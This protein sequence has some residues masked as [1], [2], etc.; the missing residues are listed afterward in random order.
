MKRIILLPKKLVSLCLRLTFHHLKNER[1]SEREREES[2]RE[3]Q[4]RDGEMGWIE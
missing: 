1:E 4:R 2:E 3:L